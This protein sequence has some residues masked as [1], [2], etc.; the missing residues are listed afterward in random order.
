MSVA[1]SN[2]R[3]WRIWILAQIGLFW[4]GSAAAQRLEWVKPSL[5]ALP[6]ARSAGAVAYDAATH[7]T[8]LFEGGIN[9]DNPTYGRSMRHSVRYPQASSRA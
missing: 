6:P 3:V 2:V 8:V 4:A 5:P 1:Q 7:S 9:N